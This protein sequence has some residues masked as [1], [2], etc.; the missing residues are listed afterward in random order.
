MALINF[1]SK[2]ARLIDD[3]RKFQAI[4]RERKRPIKPGETL[5][6]WC[7]DEGRK[8]GTARCIV[9]TKIRIV[10]EEMILLANENEWIPF[11]TPSRVGIM[12]RGGLTQRAFIRSIRRLYGL[13]FTGRLIRWGV[14]NHGQDT[15]QSQ[16][17]PF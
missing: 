15:C 11:D 10:S 7:R 13:P 6:L 4:R 16:H 5:H 9:Y 8:L 2:S 12:T 1:K 14:I 17:D 3:D